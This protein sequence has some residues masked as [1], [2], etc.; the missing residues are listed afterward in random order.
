MLNVDGELVPL[1]FLGDILDIP[2]TQRDFT[3]AVVIVLESNGRRYGIV[4]DEVLGKQQVVIKP[5]VG[6][7]ANSTGLSGGAIMSN[8]EVG[9]ILD[10]A[11]IIKLAHTTTH[12][13][14]LSI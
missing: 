5:L 14:A 12:P 3:Q 9:L 7:L 4:L 11:G 2:D 8:G 6:C 13:E 10:V 1:Y